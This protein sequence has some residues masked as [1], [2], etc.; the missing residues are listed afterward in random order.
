M[1]KRLHLACCCVLLL[2]GGCAVTEPTDKDTQ[3]IRS[4]IDNDPTT[5]IQSLS[6]RLGVSELAVVRAM[7]DAYARRVDQDPQQVWL[8]VQRWPI[9]WVDTGNAAYLGDP[10]RVHIHAH[11]LTTATADMLQISLDWQTV[12]DIWLID[13]PD[14]P[15][16]RRAIVWF[17][18]AGDP[19]LIVRVPANAGDEPL[20]GFEALWRA[21][22][23]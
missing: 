17:D 20:K 3:R 14:P 16:E 5:P 21:A 7:P 19:A 22:E 4:A 23:Q 15:G 11:D 2:L 12:E 8:A 13:Q 18:D 1:N 9:A 6:T 10:R